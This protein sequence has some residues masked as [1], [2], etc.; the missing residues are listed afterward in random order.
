MRLLLSSIAVLFMLLGGSA[1]WRDGAYAEELPGE[2]VGVP[3]LVM[4]VPVL[5]VTQTVL[6]AQTASGERATL[7]VIVQN[8]G[9]GDAS[10]V[11][12]TGTLSDGLQYADAGG[13]TRTWNLGATLAAGDSVT[14]QAPVVAPEVASTTSFTSTVTASADAVTPVSA[15]TLLTVTAPP[16]PSPSTTAR[17]SATFAP[18]SLLINP[19]QTGVAATVK[20]RN[21]GDDTATNVAVRLD[22]P[23]GLTL[24]DT[25]GTTHTW[26]VDELGPGETTSIAFSLDSSTATP[27]GTE[28]LP[29]TLVADATSTVR[30]TTPVEVRAG[31]VLGAMTTLPETGTTPWAAIVTGL[32]VVVIAFVLGKR[33]VRST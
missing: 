8:T 7:T 32:F 23:Q 29:A 10:Q 30:V 11:L 5:S 14:V 17:L 25:G 15:T 18:R 27:V 3:S 26:T 19:G 2:P 12:L 4:T 28:Q 31:S 24:A 21:D 1:G 22:L 16:A 6:P 13:S 33:L 9:T 20:V